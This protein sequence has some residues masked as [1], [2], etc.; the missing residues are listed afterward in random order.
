MLAQP[1]DELALRFEEFA[2]VYNKYAEKYNSGVNPIE[3]FAAE[4]SKRWR[5]IESTR[6]YPKD[7]IPRCKND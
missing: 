6:G 4:M 3:E 7:A 2:K 1:I 5:K